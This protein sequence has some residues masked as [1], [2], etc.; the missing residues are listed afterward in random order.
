VKPE[1]VLGAGLEV[2]A[3]IDFGNVVEAVNAQT[4]AIEMGRMRRALLAMLST[5][6]CDAFEEN[7]IEDHRVGSPF[8]RSAG[9]ARKAISARAAAFRAFDAR[10]VLSHPEAKWARTA[11]RS[12]GPLDQ[13]GR[14][15]EAYE[16]YYK[17]NWCR[18]DTTGCP[19]FAEDFA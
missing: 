5:A 6:F 16:S 8:D 3:G 4:L 2:E 18:K 13:A 9:M 7:L 19:P 17:F 11:A 12:A 15:T 10:T 1:L 14:L